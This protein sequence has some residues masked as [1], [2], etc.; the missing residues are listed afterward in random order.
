MSF[1]RVTVTQSPMDVV[2]VEPNSPA[3][4]RTTKRIASCANSLSTS[5]HVAKK[6]MKLDANPTM[7]SPDPPAGHTNVL[8]QEHWKV[9]TG[10]LPFIRLC[11]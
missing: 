8:A 5:S 10:Q 4:V 3:E 7:F 9:G 1:N 2:L 11:V 6:R